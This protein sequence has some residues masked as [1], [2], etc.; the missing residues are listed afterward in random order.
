MTN[1]QPELPL[2]WLPEVIDFNAELAS[3]F[4]TA[5]PRDR[6]EA[7]VALSGR[8]LDFIQTI[9]LDRALSKLETLLDVPASARMK[10]A[11]IGSSTL[12]HLIPGI[13]IGAL[14]RGLLVEAWLAPYG[15][16]RQE[17]LDS[18]SGL[19]AFKPD[20]VLL[21]IEATA[22]VPELP[23]DTSAEEVAAV[24]NTK[25]DEIVALWRVVK[26]QLGATLIQQTVL[27]TATPIF[28]H[29]ER[30]VPA[31]RGSVAAHF[32]FKLVD[33]AAKE[34]VL[35]L[36]LRT[37]ALSVGCQTMTNLMLWHHA[38]QEIAPT[39]TPW[40][41]DQIGRILAATRGLSK[42]LLVLDL[43]NTLWG[44]VIGDDGLEGI[45]LG[46][47]SATGEA[48]VAFQRYVKS[49]SERGVIL[50]VS[51]KNETAIVEAAFNDH[52]EMVLRQSD[53]AALEASWGDKPTAL[54]KIARDLN[55]GL[56]SLVFFDD[57]PVER[58]LMRQTLPMVAVPEVPEAVE[59]YIACLG[60][61][62]YFEAVAFTGDDRQRTTQYKA[63]SRR[64]ELEASTTDLEGYLRSL[65]MRLTVSS[66]APVDVPR[67][68]Q[69]INK[70]NQFNVTTRRYSEAEVTSIMSNPNALSFAA[71]LDDCF[72][73][74]GI[75]SIVFGHLIT[76]DNVC[77]FDIDTWLMSCRVLGRSV[78]SAL[79]AV[80]A[81]TT[82]RAGAER[83]IGHY[84]P[85][86]KNMIVQDLFPR[87]GFTAVEGPP[88]RDET[89]WEY[90][91]NGMSEEAP[92]YFSLAVDLEPV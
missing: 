75:I 92:N 34:S 33:A 26:E 30:L 67:I 66:F 50:A 90:D 43:D 73:S 22:L 61:A 71:R 40:V 18:T 39:A 82:R 48:Y 23:L 69:L 70:T 89:I 5:N 62:G 32:D 65:E 17:I 84:R 60:D 6:W 1:Q 49:L 91:L 59:R 8:R 51:S 46:Q 58:D 77:V 54:R 37:A 44:G 42:K 24:I 87:L 11:L 19:Q 63:N 55:V 79:L 9:K 31:S 2:H 7:L 20:A 13:R 85:T 78:E 14:R 29:F 80:V 52:P 3:I 16:W 56:D 27:S 36:D 47:G 38:K 88:L 25:V 57:N 15:Q 35:L 4:A 12:D 76:R 28:G 86:S 41:G 10:V 68:T 64:R 72:G 53:I 83:M 74:N 45:V 21:S 81:S